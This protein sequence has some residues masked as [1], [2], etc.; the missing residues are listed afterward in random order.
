MDAAPCLCCAQGPDVG[1]QLALVG[2]AKGNVKDESLVVPLDKRIELL[3]K[4]VPSA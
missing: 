4:H 2:M 1:D 3:K